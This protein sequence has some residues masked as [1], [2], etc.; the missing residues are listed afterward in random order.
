MM[1][2][3][4]NKIIGI[5]GAMPEE[6]GSITELLSDL[7]TRE[8]GGRTYYS[9][10]L[11]NIP[12]VVVFSRWGKV[13]AATTVTTLILEYK[14]TELVFTGVAG[15]IHPELNIGDIVIGRRLIQ[16]DLDARPIMPRFEIPLLGVSYIE[17]YGPML[18]NMQTIIRDMLSQQHLHT[19]IATKH[20]DHFNIHNPQLMMGDIASGDQ[21]FASEDAKQELLREL[22]SVLCVEMEGAAVAQVCYEYRIP[23]TIIR[24]ISDTANENAHLDFP[25]FIRHI[26]SNYS[27]E[28]IGLY[29]QQQAKIIS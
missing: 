11:N 14:I 13:A 19:V 23:F 2:N 12:A 7:N 24:T 18:S 25:S 4:S 9:G 5:M 28:I 29:F 15:A 16:H 26:S 27:R 3:N 17:S 8:I 21:F 1:L 20:L 22:P 6:I 10:L